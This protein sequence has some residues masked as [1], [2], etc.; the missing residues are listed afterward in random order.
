MVGI[1]TALIR[2]DLFFQNWQILR[3]IAYGNIYYTFFLLKMIDKTC[4][5]NLIKTSVFH[6][7]LERMRMLA[8][9]SS[10]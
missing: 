4:K 9:V 5:T 10:V 8:C 6:L 7:Y 3:A 1:Q 2:Y